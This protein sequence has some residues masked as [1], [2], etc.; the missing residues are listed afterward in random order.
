MFQFSKFMVQACLGDN[1]GSVPDYHNKADFHNKVNHMNFWVSHCIQNLCSAGKEHARQCKRHKRHRFD[2]WAGKIPW[3]RKQ[4][5]TPVF[6]PG[7]FH[8][9]RSLAGYSPWGRKELDSI[10]HM[11]MPTHTHTQYSLVSVQQLYV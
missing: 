6:L 11:C 1:A 8:G 9:E 4:Q 2:P 10:E 5:L 7:K 3:R